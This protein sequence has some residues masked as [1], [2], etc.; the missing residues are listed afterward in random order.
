MLLHNK[1][2]FLKDRN[3]MGLVLSRIIMAKPIKLFFLRRG[4]KAMHKTSKLFH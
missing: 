4:L 1:L 2:G 3:I